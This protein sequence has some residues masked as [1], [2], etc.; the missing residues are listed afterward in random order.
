[1]AICKRIKLEYFFTPHAK[2]NPKWKKDLN[3]RPQTIKILKENK[4]KALFDIS[5]SNIYIF[6]VPQNKGAKAKINK[7]NCNELK[8]LCTMKETTDKGKGQAPKIE[9][10]VAN[11]TSN[12]GLIS[13]IYKEQRVG[14]K[15]NCSVYM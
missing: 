11:D 4:G 1:M 14:K 2:I 5:L 7:L 15:C 12:K 6:S 10:M 8:C 9:K 13:K 3:V